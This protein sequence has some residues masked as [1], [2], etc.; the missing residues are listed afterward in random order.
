MIANT[1]TQSA[2]RI[3]QQIAASAAPPRND[4]ALTITPAQA[5]LS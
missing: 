5:G 1:L 4:D 3:Q 2:H